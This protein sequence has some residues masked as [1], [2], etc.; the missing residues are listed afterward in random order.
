MTI[1]VHEAPPVPD[2]D[3]DVDEWC[4]L[5]DYLLEIHDEDG[6]PDEATASER[7]TVRS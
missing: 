3:K 7:W 4:P 1:A 5:C 6:C 2:P